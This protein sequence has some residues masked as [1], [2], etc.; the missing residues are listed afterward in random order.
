MKPSLHIVAIDDHPFFLNGISECFSSLP[1]ATRVFTCGNYEAFC[2]HIE[3]QV[4][5]IAFVDLN[6]PN[7]SGFSICTELKAKHPQIFVAVL[8]QYDSPKFVEQAKLCGAG[9][10]FIKNTEP[11]VFV[12]FLED[13]RN[14]RTKEFVLHLPPQ[15]GA[16][17]FD[18]EAMVLF[19]KLSAREREVFHLLAQGLNHDEIEAKLHIVYETFKTHRT[20][21]LYKLGMKNVAELVKFAVNHHLLQAV[22]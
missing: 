10:Y 11:E 14:G 2:K 19:E 6:M 3:E 17:I 16:A 7:H 4:P 5:D 21:I 22:R 12:E 15:A 8:T 13:Y 20:N 18:G 1:F 9:A